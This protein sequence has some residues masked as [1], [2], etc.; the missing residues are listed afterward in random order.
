[1]NTWETEKYLTLPF[2]VNDNA[3]FM[4]SSPHSGGYSSAEFMVNLMRYYVTKTHEDEEKALDELFVCL[5]D[6]SMRSRGH[7]NCN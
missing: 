2:N 4:R 7:A 5:T 6:F 3:E 1:M